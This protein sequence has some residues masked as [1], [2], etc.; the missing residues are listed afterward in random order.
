[1]TPKACN[2]ALKGERGRQYNPLVRTFDDAGFY[3]GNDVTAQK[4][5]DLLEAQLSGGQPWR[6]LQVSGDG[7]CLG[8]LTCG[9]IDSR[10]AREP[11][12]QLPAHADTLAWRGEANR[13]V[14]SAGQVVR[15]DPDIDSLKSA[16]LKNPNG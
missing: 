2:T 13:A 10:T 7:R 15:D 8:A 14:Q 16:Q 4:A 12:I 1:M 3:F 11:T 9:D 5:V 6:E